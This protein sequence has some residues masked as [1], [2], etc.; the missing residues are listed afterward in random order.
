MKRGEGVSADIE[1]RHQPQGR[2]E[3]ARQFGLL[4]IAMIVNKQTW[5]NL[6][7]V[8]VVDN[9]LLLLFTNIAYG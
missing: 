9:K 6:N 8:G 7:V 3:K 2:E 1:G 4:L 5:I